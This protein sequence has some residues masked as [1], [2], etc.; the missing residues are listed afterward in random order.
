MPYGRC[1]ACRGKQRQVQRSDDRRYHTQRWRKYS[2][3]RLA[4]HPW[5]VLC[6]ERTLAAVTD[7]VKPTWSH[8]ELFW[9][10][11]N[12]QSLCVACNRA[13]ARAEQVMA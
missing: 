5:C 3:Q 2:R 9:D 4:Q 6:T 10:E 12:H 11:A 13:K 8:P 1:Q 7:H